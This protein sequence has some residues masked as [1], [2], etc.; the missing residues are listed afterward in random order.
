M[1]GKI[2]KTKLG[3]GRIENYDRPINGKIIVYL[4]DGKKIV[5]KPENIQVIG[6]FD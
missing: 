4:D 6:Y 3:K 5:C 2:V 1:A